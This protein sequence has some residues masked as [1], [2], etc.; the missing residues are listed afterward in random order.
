MVPGV[1]AIRPLAAGQ[2]DSRPSVE[3]NSSTSSSEKEPYSDDP[4]LTKPY[5]A[6]FGTKN[7]SQE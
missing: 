3:K 2:T 7:T 4:Q 5:Q 6:L 1:H